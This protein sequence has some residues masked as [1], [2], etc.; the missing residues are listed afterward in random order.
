MTFEQFAP[1][2]ATVAIQLQARDADDVMARAYFKALK[3]LEPE[4]VA[5][6]AVRLADSAEWFPKTSEW[7]TLARSIERERTEEVKARLRRLPTPLCLACDDTGWKAVHGLYPGR[8]VACDCRELRRLEVL[9]RRPMPRLPPPA[10]TGD[11]PPLDTDPRVAAAVRT[12]AGS[13]ELH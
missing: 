8:V 12:L 6:A 13:K 3:D 9:G 11:P 7:R 1:I 4:F 5:M 2:F 10:V